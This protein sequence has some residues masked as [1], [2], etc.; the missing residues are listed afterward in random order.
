MP[1]NVATTEVFDKWVVSLKDRQ[2]ARMIRQRITRVRDGNLGDVKSVGRGVFEMRVFA[3]KG[4]RLY[5]CI[6]D[7][8]LIILLCGGS[9]GSQTR[10]IKMA[11]RMLNELE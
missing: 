1:L 9:K 6:R 5:Y 8:Q 2:A 4:Y 11:Q 10:D 7:D 3:G